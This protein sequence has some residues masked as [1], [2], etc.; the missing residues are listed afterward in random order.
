M[1]KKNFPHFDNVVYHPATEEWHIHD[2]KG[3]PRCLEEDD[4]EVVRRGPNP[5]DWLRAE[6]HHIEWCWLNDDNDVL[7]WRK[8][9]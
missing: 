8:V 5:V 7:L 2:G 3:Q 4:V 9:Y 1:H 6:A